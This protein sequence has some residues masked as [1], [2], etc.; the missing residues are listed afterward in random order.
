MYVDGMNICMNTNKKTSIFI[1]ASL[2]Q[3]ST[4]KDCKNFSIRELK[5]RT[6]F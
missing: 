3:K 4:L 6:L 1:P 5:T 2:T